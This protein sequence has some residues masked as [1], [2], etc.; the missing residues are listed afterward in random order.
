MLE[1]AQTL[2]ELIAGLSVAAYLADRKTQLA[3]E[4]A[5]EILGEAARRVS[6]AVQQS[7][8]EIPWVGI[9]A[10]RNVIAHEYGEIKQERLWVVAT[11]HVEDLIPKLRLLVPPVPPSGDT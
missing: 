10:Q 4:R 6:P 2:R 3:V 7:H 9:I 5:I 8:P 11:V 1:A